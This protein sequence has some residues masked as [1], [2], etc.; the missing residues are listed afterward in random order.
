M[1]PRR[2]S[3]LEKI[4]T[5]HLFRQHLSLSLSLRFMKCLFSFEKRIF[6]VDVYT[7]IQ[8]VIDAPIASRGIYISIEIPAVQSGLNVD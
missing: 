6:K 8:N 3:L 5:R 7:Y 1:L 4:V 2:L